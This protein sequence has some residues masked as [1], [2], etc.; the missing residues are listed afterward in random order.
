ML[1]CDAILDSDD[2]IADPKLLCDVILESG[3]VIADTESLCDVIIESDV[4]ADPESLCDV[5]LESNDVIVDAKSPCDVI[6]RLLEEYFEVTKA[7][8]SLFL[9]TFLSS[10]FLL[11]YIDADSKRLVDSFSGKSFVFRVALS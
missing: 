8:F 9:W 1:R 3:D 2:V 4:I 5:I 10:D 6:L 7:P 11:L